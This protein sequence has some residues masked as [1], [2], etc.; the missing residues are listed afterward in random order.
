MSQPVVLRVVG[1][2]ALALLLVAL[3]GSAGSG[4]E[5]APVRFGL[6]TDLHAHDRDSPVEKKWMTRTAERLGAFCAAMNAEAVDFTIQL[7]DFINGWVVLGTDP[8]D[9]SRIAGILA[10]ADSLYAAFVGPRY[11]VLGNHDLYNLDKAAI[12]EILGLERTYYSFDVR[13]V[14]FVVLDVEFAEDGTDLAH[15]YTGVA[16]FLPAAESAWLREDLAR[17]DRPTVVFV[18]QM[19]DAYVEEWG[20]PIVANQPDVQAILSADAEVV[21]VFQGHDHAFRESEVTG[22]RYMTFGALVDQG[23]PASWAVVTVDPAAQ[24]VTIEGAGE[25]PSLQFSYD[26][27]RTE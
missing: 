19:L 17:C 16:G 11:H 6:F 23:T 24:T 25:Q 13:G 8:G 26:I 4:G 9:P 15:T 2:A 1:A 12:R 18:H 14:H 3:G 27:G 10:W 5:A 21:A 20:R 22:V 7:G